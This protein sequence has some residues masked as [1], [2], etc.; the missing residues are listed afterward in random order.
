MSSEPIISLHN[1]SKTYIAY[2]H[3]IQGLISHISGGHI[4]R[5]KKFHALNNVSIEIYK[6]ETVGIIGRNGS[7]K[8]TLLQI[9]CG[10]RQPTTGSVSIKGRISALLELGSGFQ[11]EFT[12]RENI[13][14][15]GAIVGI[16][17]E[18]MEMRF[19]EISSF[20][21]IGEYLDQPLRTYST[22]MLVRLAFAVAVAVDPDILIVDEALAVGD[23]LFQSKCFNKFRE[24][25]KKGVTILFVTHSLDLVASHCQRSLLLDTG[26]LV[27]SGTPK[28][29][30]DAYRKLLTTRLQ[31][32][33][34]STLKKEPRD[35]S[36]IWD[37]MF[38]TNSQEYRY[39]SRETEIIEAGLFTSDGQPTQL[40][41]Y[42]QDCLIKIRLLSHQ[43]NLKPFISFVIKDLK[44]VV[45]CGTN[46]LAENTYLEKNTQ[47]GQV[48]LILFQMP[49][50]LNPGNY[51]L[52]VGSQVYCTD[53][54]T[55][56]H[57]HRSD[58]L[59][60]EVLGK[61]RYGIFSAPLDV[62]L[63]SET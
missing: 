56:S 37:G 33:D 61:Q 35:S 47:T 44:G 22:G 2:N 21:D 4:G 17:H 57:D 39:G 62:S 50:F 14:L 20:A 15:Q 38:K 26:N 45:L 42:G 52:S 3:P 11:M 23:S 16:S 53:G 7:G 27:L 36:L 8:S 30:I 41:L 48:F 12:G 13:F 1:V 29:T 6:G 60:F 18:E 32:Q 40:F 49:I 58:Y 43:D 19:D 31:G 24:F 34:R 25:Q 59:P 55:V 63:E 46:T 9:I 10:I 51:L 28:E 54:N 5:H